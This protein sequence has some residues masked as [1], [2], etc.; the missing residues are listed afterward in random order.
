MRF[1][2][3]IGENEGGQN[4]TIMQ[5]MDDSLRQVGYEQLTSK[6]IANGNH[7]EQ[8]WREDFA[9]AYLWLF[10][11]FANYVPD[12]SIIRPLHIYRNSVRDDLY[13]QNVEIKAED[14]I[15][16]YNMKGKLIHEV[17]GQSGMTLNV[18]YLEKGSYIIKV[19]TN[20]VIFRA[21]FVK[22]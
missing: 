16:I 19:T 5:M 3:N 10:A 17:S 20:E 14:S 12:N 8:T 18:D 2:Q 1:Y 13:I 15:K 22:L 6:V 21:K 7:N 9:S 11:S 4:I